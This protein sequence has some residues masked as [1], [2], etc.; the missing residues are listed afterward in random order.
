MTDIADHVLFHTLVEIT[1]ILIISE[2]S[3]RYV[4]RPLARFDYGRTFQVMKGW[5]SKPIISKSK[6]WV[7]PGTLLVAIAFVGFVTAPKNAVT[8]FG[9]SV[10]LD[11]ATDLQELYP[12]VVVDGD[13]GRQLYASVP[14]IE[15][16]KEQDLLKDTILI[17]LGTNGSFSEA[18]FDS[19][20]DAIG[21]RKVYW[22][23]VRVPTKRWQNDVNAMLEQM[24]KKYDNMTLIDWYSYS[25]DH[26]DW[27]YDDQ[28]HP[29]PEG[30]THYIHLV[31]EALLGG[32]SSTNSSETNVSE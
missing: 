13:V 31:S 28:V 1:L 15:K 12:K 14:Y 11:A 21:D 20:M 29:N 2:L 23:N 25:N 16:L 7:V 19:V 4:E 8:A 32:S 24:T 17:G 18:Q 27:F 5:F 22:V 9:D 3:Y 10:M 30:M 26:S 6:P